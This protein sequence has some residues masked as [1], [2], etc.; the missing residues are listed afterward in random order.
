M[1]S[2]GYLNGPLQM[3]RPANGVCNYLALEKIYGMLILRIHEF[4]QLNYKVCML[5]K[6]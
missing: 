3:F 5:F 6:L 2:P 1:S 4:C